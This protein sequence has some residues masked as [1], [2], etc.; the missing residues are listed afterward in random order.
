M[1]MMAAFKEIPW[2]EIYNI[3]KKLVGYGPNDIEKL[4]S[5]GK[6]HYNSTMIIKG[7]ESFNDEEIFHLILGEGEV[8][9]EDIIAINEISYLK[10]LGGFCFKKN[11][12]EKTMIDYFNKF[13]EVF[14]N[15]DVYLLFPASEM[16]AVFQHDGALF[17]YGIPFE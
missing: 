10:D 5:S 1:N 12:I 9:G 15:G 2:S 7:W 4:I 6:V 8:K 14:F 11:N 17:F 16:L 13:N 3:F